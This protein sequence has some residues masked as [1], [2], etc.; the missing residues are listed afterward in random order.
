MFDD[1]ALIKNLINSN[2]PVNYAYLIKKK[3]VI[4]IIVNFDCIIS[5]VKTVTDLI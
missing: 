3:A 2:N 5:N 1:I 4:N